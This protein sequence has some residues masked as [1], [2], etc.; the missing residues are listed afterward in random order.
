M[1]ISENTNWVDEFSFVLSQIEKIFLTHT[2]TFELGSSGSS[3]FINLWSRA[4]FLPSFVIF[5]ILSSVGSTWL[6]LTASA[7]SEIASNISFCSSVG[8]VL[9]TSKFA[10]G[11]GKFNISEVFISATSLNMLISSGKL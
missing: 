7:L 10:S 9:I 3:G 8:F 2:L 4:S 5:N 1:D 6:F 11:T